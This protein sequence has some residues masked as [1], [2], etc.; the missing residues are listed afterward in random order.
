MAVSKPSDCLVGAG[1]GVPRCEFEALGAAAVGDARPGDH[2]ARVGSAVGSDV[3]AA[4]GFKLAL[5]LGRDVPPVPAQ[6]HTSIA[7]DNTATT[8]RALGS[9]FGHLVRTG[10]STLKSFIGSLASLWPLPY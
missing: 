9:L 2:S 6:A 1:V 3:N 4:V 5:A 8:A 7:A 10:I